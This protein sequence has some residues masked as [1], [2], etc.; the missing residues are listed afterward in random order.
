MRFEELYTKFGRTKSM[1]KTNGILHLLLQL[2]NDPRVIASEHGNQPVLTP[3]QGSV[4]ESVFSSKLANQV[5]YRAQQNPVP[6]SSSATAAAAGNSEMT[7]ARQSTK[8]R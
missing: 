2:S 6:A 8:Q 4:I 7:E 3:A 5:A 1:N